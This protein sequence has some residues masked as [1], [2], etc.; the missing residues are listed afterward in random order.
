MESF[1]DINTLPLSIAQVDSIVHVEPAQASAGTESPTISPLLQEQLLAAVV[2][3]VGEVEAAE[4]ALDQAKA[5]RYAQMSAAMSAGVAAESVAA[6]AGITKPA[7]AALVGEK[8][9]ASVEG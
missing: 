2:T 4:W 8:A 7:R 9:G 1:T 3:R 6:A 5:A